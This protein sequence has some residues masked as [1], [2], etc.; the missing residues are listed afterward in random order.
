MSV[1]YDSADVSY[2][3][4]C[5]VVEP[6]APLTGV[7]DVVDPSVPLA[8]VCDVVEPPVLDLNENVAARSNLGIYCFPFKV[9]YFICYL[10][11][12]ISKDLIKIGLEYLS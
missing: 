6:P 1:V 7:C 9:L 3:G 12:Q 8:G 2:T 5:D 4:V 11:Q 10:S